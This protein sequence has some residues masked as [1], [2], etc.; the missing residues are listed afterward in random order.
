[1]SEL[2]R[3][4]LLETAMAYLVRGAAVQYDQ[5]SM[6]RILQLTP[7]R[8]KFLPPEAATGQHTLYLDCSGFV[9]AVYWQA[10]GYELPSDLT[11]HMIDLVEPQVYCGC[12]PHT[13]DAALRMEREL[14]ALLRPG[15][16]ITFELENGNGHT[17]LCLD[18]E[19]YINCSQNGTEGGY[20]YVNRRNR[21]RKNGGI[22]I[23]RI[24]WLFHP[25]TDGM[26]R[27][28]LFAADVRRFAVARPLEKVGAPTAAALA[29]L[30]PC[31]GLRCGVETSHPGGHQAFPGERVEYRLS[32][33]NLTAAPREAELSFAFPGKEP[34]HRTLRLA[35]GARTEM[36]FAVCAA[37][38]GRPWLPLPEVTVC[39]LPVWV[40]RV[41]CG[42][43]P[44]P[45]G[46][47]RLLAD[48]RQ[49]MDAGLLAMAAITRAYG[50]QGIALEE[51]AADAVRARFY[52]HDAVPGDVLSRR[53][54][55]PGK[56]LGV[57]SMYGG[58]GVVTPEMGSGDGGRTTQI[59]RTDL[60]PGDVIVC[61]DD[62]CGGT[63]YAVLYSGAELY[64]SLEYGEAPHRTGGAGVD[65]FL[66]SLPGR[67]CFVLL[68]PWMEE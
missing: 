32:V 46:I 45:D 2:V 59:G 8:R 15:D 3:Q 16:V 41:L 18:A 25:R 65:R 10:F 66:D 30:G 17:M 26:L 61:A 34:E 51:R 1:M 21:F 36:V 35:P 5:R 27:N 7:R 39:G 58:T 56:D 67:F 28:N 20:D 62:A 63:A 54:Q 52:L 43:E 14:R 40:P 68:R 29:R 47:G 6:D 48:A 24:D 38:D 44:P 55:R 60:L 12:P 53:R 4:A 31:R 64:G 37:A 9:S 42:R 19:R 57:Y 50:A 33:Q 49:G 22:W 23:E 13:A 11:W